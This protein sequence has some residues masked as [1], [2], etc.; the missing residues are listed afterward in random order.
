M[1]SDDGEE[2]SRFPYQKVDARDILYGANYMH[3]TQ[4]NTYVGFGP[5]LA[6]ICLERERILF[7]SCMYRA[8]S[9]VP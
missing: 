2:V 1:I 3:I 8:T 4:G 6:Q 9:R 5:L 7:C